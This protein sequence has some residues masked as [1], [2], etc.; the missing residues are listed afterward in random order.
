MNGKLLTDEDKMACARLMQ[1]YIGGKIRDPIS[2]GISHP[3][4][5]RECLHILKNIILE[6][7]SMV[8]GGTTSS[9]ISS[10][11]SKTARKKDVMSISSPNLKALAEE[12]PTPDNRPAH[13]GYEPIG[14]VENSV[15]KQAWTEIP[16]NQNQNISSLNSAQQKQRSR[17][18]SPRTVQQK[19]QTTAYSERNTTSPRGG[20]GGGEE[21]VT[22]IQSVST[23]RT[24]PGS[25]IGSAVSRTSGVS[26]SSSMSAFRKNLLHK[27]EGTCDTS[28]VYD[29]IRHFLN[30]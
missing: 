16:A 20:G 9:N 27:E 10:S 25:R 24:Q 15:K 21:D 23:L 28:H 4:K 2:A 30:L 26:R 19:N 29:Y 5:F 7:G 3:L 18:V 14:R 6:S 1:G 17:S 11:Y 8:N 12:K 22:E 13:K